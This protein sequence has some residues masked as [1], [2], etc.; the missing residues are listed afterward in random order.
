MAVAQYVD[1]NAGHQI[2]VATTLV[3]PH[4]AAGSAHEDERLASV[5]RHL[6]RT[7]LRCLT[8]GVELQ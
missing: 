2:Q 5:D 4:P 7:I 1:R 8:Y 3:I 6:E